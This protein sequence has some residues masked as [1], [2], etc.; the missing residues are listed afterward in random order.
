MKELLKRLRYKVFYLKQ[1]MH[2][3]AS[4]LALL[5]SAMIIYL[6][7][8]QMYERG[9]INFNVEKYFFPLVVM[10]FCLLVFWGWFEVKILKGMQ[11]EAAIGFNLTPPFVEMRDKINDLWNKSMT[12]VERSKLNVN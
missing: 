4:Y 9:V 10:G 6:V 2:R 12:D 1:Y 5:N 8:S 7:L 3:T 11:E